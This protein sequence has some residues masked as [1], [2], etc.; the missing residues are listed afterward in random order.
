MANASHAAGK[1]YAASQI[2]IAATNFATVNN[3][4]CDPLIH[5]YL[6]LC[7]D[8]STSI[9]T[10]TL[11]NLSFLFKHWKEACMVEQFHPEVLVEF[12]I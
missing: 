2:I 11:K 1:R 8:I 12:N 7:Q 10:N 6:Y 4:P 9:R 3:L 5:N